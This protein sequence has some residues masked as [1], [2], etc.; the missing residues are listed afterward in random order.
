MGRVATRCAG[1]VEAVGN[2][3]ARTAVGVG[4]WGARALDLL[5]YAA[6]GA[7]GACCR[8]RAGGV[9][10]AVGARDAVRQSQS[11]GKLPRKT[12]GAYSEAVARGIVPPGG[13][14]QAGASARGVGEGPT[15]TERAVCT[16][17]QPTGI[18][19]SGAGGAGG[20]ASCGVVG[21]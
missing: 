6:R 17:A 11:A 15:A 21:P 8:A 3:R 10:A 7:G 2:L 4:D 14:Q 1:D 13:T 19:S 18:L 9:G 16:R 20:G 12:Q 5:A